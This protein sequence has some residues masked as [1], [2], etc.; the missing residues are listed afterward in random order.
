MP[1]L[2]NT[3]HLLEIGE[4]PLPLR[5]LQFLY[6]PQCG[7]IWQEHQAAAALTD[8]RHV[9]RATKAQL[10]GYI[11][12]LLDRAHAFCPGRPPRIV[13][14]GCNDGAFLTR[15]LE[16]GYACRLGVEPSQKLAQVCSRTGH[17]TEC[18]LF[19]HSAA[20]D[21]AQRHGTADVLFVRH[22]LEHVPDPEDFLC[23]LRVLLARDGVLFLEVPD[24]ASTVSALLGHELWDEHLSYFTARTLRLLLVRHGFEVLE[25]TSEPHRA[26]RNLLC[27]ARV[28]RS[29]GVD[30][31]AEDAAIELAA[32]RAFGV[33]WAALCARLQTETET[34]K[35]PVAALGASHPQLNFFW[36]AGLESRVQLLAD[37]DE[38]K[39]GRFL[40][41]GLP[42][43]VV[44]AVKLWEVWAPSTL[45]RTAFGCGEWT[46][47]M[48]A[49][50]RKRGVR[51]VDPYEV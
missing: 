15:A 1:P 29:K 23:G 14:I 12:V 19:C 30:P 2:P 44:S 25:L 32:C 22:V 34:W 10:P 6:C 33:R 5:P 48:A 24:T 49:A 37:D 45:L 39:Q 51:V 36:Y 3:G 40:Q 4:P 16:H 8:Y 35:G 7:F 50:A 47:Q 18:T 38:T 28:A 31:C 27:W 43:P 9:G 26:G 42:V 11:D 13:D 20:L 17:A 46:S 21:L 41:L